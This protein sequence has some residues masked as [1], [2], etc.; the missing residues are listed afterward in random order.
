[1][2][3][4]KERLAQ[5]RKWQRK[6]KARVRRNHRRWYERNKLKALKYS[7]RAYDDFRA[8]LA[9][10]KAVPCTDCMLKLPAVVMEFDH[11][12]GIKSFNV[13]S[14][15]RMKREKVEAELLKCD[16]V[17][18]NCHRIRTHNRRQYANKCNNA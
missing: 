15:C 7:A 14:A 16:V 10:K 4:S 6:N 5:I 12:R 2:K 18:A 3:V 17:C 8:W 13:A 1:M 9:V 11:T